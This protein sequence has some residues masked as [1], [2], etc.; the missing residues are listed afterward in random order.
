M[1][2]TKLLKT[3]A[4]DDENVVSMMPKSERNETMIV[5]SAGVLNFS[6]MLEKTGGKTPSRAIERVI[7]AAGSI[8]LVPY[9]RPGTPEMGDR[10]LPFLPD[11]R[12]LILARHGALA[13][14]ETLEE[15]YN[16]MERLEH[17]CQI[18]K[19]AQELGGAQPLPEAEQRALRLA[20]ERGG[21]RLL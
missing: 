19:S 13:W 20:R 10:L 1:F 11:H 14:G 17:V 5:P 7:L 16:G 15:A 4:L 2:K 8:P 6:W 12:L 3:F 21:R 9:A 18:L